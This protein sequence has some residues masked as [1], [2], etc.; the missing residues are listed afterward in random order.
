LRINKAEA[1]GWWVIA[2]NRPSRTVRLVEGVG[3]LLLSWLIGTC[4]HEVVGHGLVGVLAGGRISYVKI[5]AVEL[6][7]EVRWTGFEMAYGQCQ[8][9][10][11]PTVGGEAVHS[12]AGSMSTW[13]VGVAATILLWMRR[14]GRP[15]RVVLI[16]LSIWWMDLLTYTLPTWGLRRSILWGG[17]YS[18]PYEAAVNLGVPGPVFQAFVV[19]TSFVLAAAL[20]VRLMRDARGEGQTR[21]GMQFIKPT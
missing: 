20:I 19:G 3:L 4:W 2:M 5:F 6:W 1:L 10:G 16:Y 13:C 8:V 7:P 12:L 14:W 9:D 18:E 11:I 21:G 15:W 17:R